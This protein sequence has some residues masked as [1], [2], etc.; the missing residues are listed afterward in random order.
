MVEITGLY[1]LSAHIDETVWRL[2]VGLAHH[3]PFRTRM[4]S[5]LVPMV[6]LG[7]R[8]GRLAGLRAY[9][10]ETSEVDPIVWTVERP[11]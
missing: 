1:S 3:I 6:L 8:S 7:E 2:D 4:L 10:K 9:K 5:P 11:S